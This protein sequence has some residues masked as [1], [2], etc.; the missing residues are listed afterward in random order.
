MEEEEYQGVSFGRICKVAFHRW[1]L[2]LILTFSICLVGFFGVYFGYNYFFNV[3]NATFS[4]SGSGLA[5]ETK[6]DNTTFNYKSLVSK[7]VLNEVKASN[8]EYAGIDV[9]ALVKAN[10]FSISRAVDKDSNEISYTVSIKRNKMPSADI[11]RD[12]FRDLANHPLEQD[13]AY[14][15]DST[16]DSALQKYQDVEKYEDA[17]DLL[18]TQASTMINGYNT[19]KALKISATLSD[20]IASNIYTINSII[21]SSKVSLLKN[22]IINYGLTPDYTKI[23]VASLAQEK[24]VLVGEDG[25]GGEKKDNQDLIDSFKATIISLGDKAQV[26]GLGERMES[27]IVRNHNIDLKVRQIDEQISNYNKKPAEVEGHEQFIK[28]MTKVYNDLAAE[29]PAYKSAMN[30]VYVDN[31]DVTFTNS[32]VLDVTKSMSLVFSILIPLAA[33][34]VVGIIV[35]LIVDRKMLYEEE[36]AVA[37]Q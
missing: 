5:T 32:N 10:A 35:N 17:V 27:L 14:I 31:A 4:Y 13:K 21:D 3:Y 16:F 36:E 29:I 22:M 15:A 26:T 37:A 24:I 20:K 2:L 8:E 7:E 34:L 23:N 30:E 11:T 25:N 18:S 33:G 19:M 12:F 9:D 28:D 6:A 1:K